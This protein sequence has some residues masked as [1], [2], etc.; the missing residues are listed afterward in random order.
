[1]RLA[2]ASYL[3]AIAEEAD[4]LETLLEANLEKRVPACPS[5]TARDLLAH[6]A[7]L[8]EF[9]AL[10]I[11]TATPGTRVAPAEA[12]P[13]ESIAAAADRVVWALRDAGPEAPCWNWSGA[14]EET[15][16]VAR[17]VAL[18][19]A[20]HRVDGEQSQGRF[21]PVELELAID[22]IEQRIALHLAGAL[23][24]PSDASLGGTL[25][26][27]CSD[28]PAA[29]VVEV[30]RGRLRWRHGRGPA[31]A[32]VVGGASQLFLFT[33]NRVGVESLAL[34]GDPAVAEAWRQ[35]PCS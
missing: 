22:G 13:A 14:E 23:Q 32:V 7:W 33:W 20:V 11:A 25:C 6:V 4:R 30:E 2:F 28:A 35:L 29:F 9:W 31:D 3:D 19:S 21:L 24:E 12:P 15:S 17:H 8:Y 10:Q 16:F 27:V 1:V 34:T 26:L 18:E 5:W